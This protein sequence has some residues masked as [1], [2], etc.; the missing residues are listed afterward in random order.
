VYKRQVPA[1]FC[2]LKE[3]RVASASAGVAS[4]AA[5][6]YKRQDYGYTGRTDLVT[7]LRLSQ[8]P[9]FRNLPVS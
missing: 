4:A 6:M 7:A 1:S 2:D 8:L 5:V 3:D 9:R